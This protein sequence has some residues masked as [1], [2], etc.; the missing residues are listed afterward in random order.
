MKGVK[1]KRTKL[2][3][4]FRYFTDY[5]KPKT[6]EEYENILFSTDSKYLMAHNGWVM[7]ADPMGNFAD[8][9][10]NIYIRRELIAWG[11][12]VKLRLVIIYLNVML[13]EP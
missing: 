8:S 13:P 1:I 9:N 10:S 6:I 2:E 7:N 11:D 12:S 4:L 3:N 5:G